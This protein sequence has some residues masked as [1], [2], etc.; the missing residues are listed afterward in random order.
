MSVLKLLDAVDV[1]T[2]GAGFNGDGGAKTLTV[3]ADDYGGGTITLQISDDGGTHWVPV[4]YN[5]SDFSA[6]ADTSREIVKVSQGQ[7]IRATLSGSTAASN[8]SVYLAS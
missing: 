4:T 7:L 3:F 2:V 6:T 5:G 8:V 1:D